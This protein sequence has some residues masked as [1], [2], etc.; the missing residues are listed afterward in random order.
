MVKKRIRVGIA[1]S[2][3]VQPERGCRCSRQ[4]SRTGS[5]HRIALVTDR[6]NPEKAWPLSQDTE[7]EALP[8][9]ARSVRHA[10]GSRSVILVGMMGAGKSSIGRRLAAV[11]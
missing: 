7:T 10:L 2:A 1:A 11:L 6:L 8:C 4:L 5:K 9:L 3:L